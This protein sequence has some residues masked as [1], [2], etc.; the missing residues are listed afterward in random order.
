MVWVSVDDSVAIFV[1]EARIVPMGIIEPRGD[2]VSRFV[3]LRRGLSL[4]IGRRYVIVYE[5]SEISRVDKI[6]GFFSVYF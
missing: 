2:F 6:K 4:E 3:N 1:D 5:S